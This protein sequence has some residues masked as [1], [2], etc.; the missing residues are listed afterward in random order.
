LEKVFKNFRSKYNNIL[1]PFI[2]KDALKEH[3]SINGRIRLKKDY[4]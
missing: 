3:L 4:P 2:K 1:L